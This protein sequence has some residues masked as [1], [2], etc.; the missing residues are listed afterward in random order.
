V[1]APLAALDLPFKLLVLADEDETKVSYTAPVA[2]A[3]RYALDGELAAALTGID[4]LTSV[5]IQR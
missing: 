3:A 1:A 2:L 5:V 4:A